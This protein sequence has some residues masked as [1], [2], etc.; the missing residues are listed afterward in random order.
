MNKL[1]I[2]VAVGLALTAFVAVAPT[3]SA[4]GWEF[5]CNTDEWAA[6]EAGEAYACVKT[7][8]VGPECAPEFY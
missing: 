7:G 4:C 5:T 3:A 2:V 1:V 6:H 8:E